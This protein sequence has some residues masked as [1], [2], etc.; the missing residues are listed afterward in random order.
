LTADMSKGEI[1][2]E[3]AAVLKRSSA[4]F[5][6][7]IGIWT[8]PQRQPRMAM[9]GRQPR[10]QYQMIQQTLM[11]N[12]NLEKIDLGQGRVPGDVDVLLLI[13]PQNLTNM[14]RFAI[15]QYLMKG[16]A[17]VALAGNYLLDLS[18]YSRVLQVKKVKNGLADL[19]SSYGIKVGQSLVLDKQNEPFPIPVT[20][21]LGGL[22]V[23]EIRMLD[24]PFFVDV[25]GN[26]M[27]KDSPIVANLPAVTMNWVSPLTIDPAKSKGRKVVRLLTSSPDSWLRSSTNIQPDLQRYPQE[28]FAPG[29]KMK[30]ELLAVS[31]QGVFNSYF[32][33]RP[34]PRQV[35]REKEIKAA[36]AAKSAK[37]KAASRQQ[38]TVNLPLGPVIKKS[39]AAARLV[40]VGS[41]E[42]IDDIVLQISRSTSH[43]RFLNN[44]GFVQNSVDWAVEDEDL[45]AIRSRGSQSR[46]LIPL[47]RQQEIFWEWLNYAAALLAL[48]LVSLYG[49]LRRRKEKPMALDPQA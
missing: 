10:A 25:R 14:E 13:A 22:Q 28:G 20:R 17:V 34:D 8:P 7:T 38:K 49:G 42:F 40:V 21:N 23:Q 11:A 45:L 24:Y 12:Y 27:D 2:K 18:P 46:L 6:K 19:L 41:S 37:G 3:I 32:A 15:D 35:E 26:G 30:R 48:V 5:L 29:R 47:T 9:M 39:P 31:E 44:M 4:G 33:D 1:K 16:R 43:D 36:A